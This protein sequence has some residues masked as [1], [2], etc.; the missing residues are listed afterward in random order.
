MN[1]YAP[2]YYR[3]FKCIKDLCRHNCCIGWEIH[4]DE[5]TRKKYLSNKSDF[6][7]TIRENITS[8]NDAHF[9]LKDN[10][11]CPFLNDNNLCD[12][13][14]NLGEDYLCQICS[15]HPRYINL[16]ETRKEIGLGLCCEAATK[17]ILSKK[18]KVCLIPLTEESTPTD[19]ERDFFD[20]RCNILSI[21]Q[22]RDLNI[23]ERIISLN[24][25]IESMSFD[26]IFNILSSLEKLDDSWSEKLELLKSSS[27]F[28][29]M[30]FDKSFEV[31]FEQIL[32]YFILRHL[33]DAYFDFR[34]EAAVSF[35]IFSA[36]AI[37]GICSGHLN[38]YGKIQF[39]NL[40]DFTREY[41]AEIEY[42]EENME[43]IFSSLS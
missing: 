13:I 15:D 26:E 32:V 10:S 43:K 25:G 6:G 28:S 16:F 38:K 35:A 36:M 17:I 29:Q 41:S 18:D 42:N 8:G 40:M 2:N 23:K 12:I 21:L 20:L 7:A 5:D 11:R 14:I 31:A 33:S 9:I 37:M 27:P 1:I 30:V 3:D 22:N 34:E 19:E 24:T 39:E 4:I